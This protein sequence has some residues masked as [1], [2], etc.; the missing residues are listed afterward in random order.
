MSFSLTILNKLVHHLPSHIIA[1][2][3]IVLVKAI[4]PL[5]NYGAGLLWF[6]QFCDCFSIPKETCMLVPKSLLS[7]FITTRG[8]GSIG[9]GAM[10]TWLL[11]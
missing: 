6:T 9:S 10:R 4:K 7:H 8:A 1:R 11:A 3:C 5:S 2:E